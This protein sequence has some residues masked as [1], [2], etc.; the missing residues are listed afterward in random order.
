MMRYCRSIGEPFSIALDVVITILSVVPLVFQSKD[1]I[2][3]GK[4]LVII[5]A[6]SAA[7][8]LVTVRN[9]PSRTKSRKLRPQIGC[10]PLFISRETETSSEMEPN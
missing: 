6:Y 7:K 2:L 10:A 4:A 1:L 8:S 3:K 5:I 9:L